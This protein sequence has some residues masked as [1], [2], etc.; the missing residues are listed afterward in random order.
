M[1]VGH[2]DHGGVAVAVAVLLCRLDKRV[3]LGRRQVLTGAEFAVFAMKF[4]PSGRELS[5]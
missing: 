5:E 4:S 3:N 1:P 2:Q